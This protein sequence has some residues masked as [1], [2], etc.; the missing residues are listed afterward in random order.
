MP[1]GAVRSASRRIHSRGTANPLNDDLVTIR[2]YRGFLVWLVMAYAC[3]LFRLVSTVNGVIMKTAS[4]PSFKTATIERP[5]SAHRTAAATN[6]IVG[7][8]EEGGVFG[9]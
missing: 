2:L 5:A 3:S 9:V 7:H 6:R 1:E 4:G 8:Y